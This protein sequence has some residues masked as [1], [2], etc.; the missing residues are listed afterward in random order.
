MHI[1]MSLYIHICKSQ[2]VYV[3]VNI[4]EYFTLVFFNAPLLVFPCIILK[5]RQNPSECLHRSSAR[6]EAHRSLAYLK[7]LKIT[8]VETLLFFPLPK[9]HQRHR[10]A[11]SLSVSLLWC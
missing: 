3:L 11:V 10:K 5:S 6:I 4:Q 8:S 2:K 9:R 7:H 1:H